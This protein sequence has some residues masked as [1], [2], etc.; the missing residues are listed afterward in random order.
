LSLF[1]RVFII[2]A[3]LVVAATATLALS[4][5]TISSTL[6]L[7]EVTVLAVGVALVLVL[8]F[9]LVRRSL[10]PLA[11]L[12][13]LMRRVDPLR[14]GARIAPQGGGAEIE[15]LTT[16][17]NQMLERLE[18]E[19]RDSGRRAIQAQEA[20]RHRIALELHDEVG[21][22]LTGVVLGLDSLGRS[23]DPEVQARVVEIRDMV[24]QGAEQVR[25]LARGLRPESL[26][27][28]G[29]RSALIGLTASVANRGGVSVER[30]IA[31]DLPKLS[32]DAELV[33]YRVAQESLTNV[34]RHAGA[35]RVEVALERRNGAL[36]LE[37][38]D[39][40]RGITAADLR[41]GR[42]LSG[43]LE[44]ALYV[45]GQLEVRPVSPHGTSVALSVPYSQELQ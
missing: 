37:V 29:L 35:S 25:E 32:P 6:L 44:R 3:A 22:M 5:A 8:N 36:H 24:R 14:P 27:E 4:P 45:E 16:A 28:L 10:D 38:R 20:E 21:Q 12:T 7:R 13:R 19:R 40:G 23:L 31:A 26:Q 42:G 30:R 9:L 39:D 18:R 1:W 11:R 41:A 43:M 33:V 2:N 17:F 34:L 15:E